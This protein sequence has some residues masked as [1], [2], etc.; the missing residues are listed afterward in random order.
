MQIFSRLKKKY[1]LPYVSRL[2]K[3]L[4]M[5]I[6]PIFLNLFVIFIFKFCGQSVG[7]KHHM[8]PSQTPAVY[9]V[10]GRGAVHH[11][12]RSLG[13]AQTVRDSHGEV[14][15]SGLLSL[16]FL[17]SCTSTNHD[18]VCGD[19]CASAS[20]MRSGAARRSP[21]VKYTCHFFF[22]FL[23]FYIPPLCSQ[24]GIAVVGRGGGYVPSLCWS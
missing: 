5:M 21:P 12:P 10:N 3:F 6:A 18:S 15:R 22:F 2:L 23:F 13:A 11:L 19:L 7:E 4:K 14:E 17:K 9:V 20:P 1:I 24:I 16:L 8:Y